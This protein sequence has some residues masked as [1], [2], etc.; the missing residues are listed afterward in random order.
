MEFIIYGPTKEELWASPEFVEV[1]QKDYPEE[2]PS[3]RK[4]QQKWGFLNQGLSCIEATDVD[5]VLILH[6]KHFF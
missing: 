5:P 4:R 6:N 1:S 2:R 3:Q